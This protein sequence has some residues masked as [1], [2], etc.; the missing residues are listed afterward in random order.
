MEVSRVSLEF[1]S[2]PSRTLAAIVLSACALG[3]PRGAAAQ[4]PSPSPSPS[5][6]VAPA[7]D[8]PKKPIVVRDHRTIRSFPEIGRAHV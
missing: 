4:D 7:E 2:R 5:P 8:E 1:S 6:S 3:V